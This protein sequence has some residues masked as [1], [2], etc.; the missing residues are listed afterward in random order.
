MARVEVYTT[1]M[2]P[3]CVAAK[4]LLTERGIPYVEFD[5]AED[6]ALRADVMRR[7]GRRTVPQI[8]ID[9]RSIGGFEE[10][11][12]LDAAGELDGLR[13]PAG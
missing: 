7:S 12:E 13:E 3:Y 5:V 11:R 2:C 10:L 1:P 6:A 8:F 9:G 4:R